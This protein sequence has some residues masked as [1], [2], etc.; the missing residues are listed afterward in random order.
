MRRA[1]RPHYGPVLSTR[2]S[3]VTEQ[4][5]QRITRR[6]ALKKG[7]AV[8][9]AVL[10]LAPA[11]QTLPRPALA[12][13]VGSPVFTCCECR[14]GTAGA[15]RCTGTGG[16]ECTTTAAGTTLAQCQTYCAGKGK[17]YCFHAGPNPITCSSPTSAC[18]AH[19]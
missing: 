9:G 6:D 10:W 5:T 3:V 14:S 12:D 7:A 11:I 8:G 18:S 19:A 1:T 13:V 17:G 2:E 4:T 16:R 15:E